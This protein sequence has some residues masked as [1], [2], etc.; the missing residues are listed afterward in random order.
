[1]S[2]SLPAN[3]V[4]ILETAGLT[5]AV[6]LGLLWLSLVVWTIRDIRARTDSDWAWVGA[7]LLVL[8]GNLL[9]LIL[10]L[11]LR[12][13]QTRAQRAARALEDELLRQESDKQ[14]LCPS[15][16][17]PVEADYLVCPGCGTSLRRACF[18]CAR[19]NDLGW[20]HCPYC[21]EPAPNL[22][23]PTAQLADPQ[24]WSVPLS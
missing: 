17:R 7:G 14:R 15:C 2:I 12:P 4:S 5:A 13:P 24:S 18:S 8:V 3:L 6:Y 23:D 11:I 9:G 21:G 16:E 22:S 19:L 10:Y 1:M 20:R